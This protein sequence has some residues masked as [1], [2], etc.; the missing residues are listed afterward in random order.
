M[1]SDLNNWTF[2]LVLNLITSVAVT[3]MYD[4][5]LHFHHR[6]YIDEYK[7]HQL[8]LNTGSLELSLPQEC[9]MHLK[10]ASN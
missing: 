10:L 5:L 2:N 3:Y 1:A 9:K 7:N 6:Y 8:F 4:S